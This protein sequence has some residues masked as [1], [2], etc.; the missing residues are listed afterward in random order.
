MDHGLC[1]VIYL[2]RRAQ[3]TGAI[4]RDRLQVDN[5]GYFDVDEVKPNISAVLSTFNEGR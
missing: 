5:A 2:D 4:K 1:N 3:E